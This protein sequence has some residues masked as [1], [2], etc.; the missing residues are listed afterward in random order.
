MSLILPAEIIFKA[1]QAKHFVIVRAIQHGN[2]CLRGAA[3]EEFC[4]IY[5]RDIH[6]ESACMRGAAGDFFVIV[7]A[8]QYRNACL[9]GAAGENSGFRRPSKQ[10]SHL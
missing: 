5:L 7:R 9:R 2:V 4:C 10:I 1:S 6:Y 8:I 3:G